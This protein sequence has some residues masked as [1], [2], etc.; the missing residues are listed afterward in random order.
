MW[1]VCPLITEQKPEHICA[2][3]ESELTTPVQTIFKLLFTPVVEEDTQSRISHIAGLGLAK[4]LCICFQLIAFLT[5][6]YFGSL[7][8]VLGVL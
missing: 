4:Y 7:T 8:Q 6:C 5:Q 2:E 1:V 3:V